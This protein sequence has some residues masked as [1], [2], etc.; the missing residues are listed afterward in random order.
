MAPKKRAGKTLLDQVNRNHVASVKIVRDCYQRQRSSHIQQCNGF[1]REGVRKVK[2]QKRMEIWTRAVRRGNRCY[3]RSAAE[4]ITS[5][6]RK[7]IDV[8]D[9]LLHCVQ[10]ILRDVFQV[11]NNTLALG[12]SGARDSNTT[13][14]E[15]ARVTAHLKHAS[16]TLLL[17]V[18]SAKGKA[19]VVPPPPP[20]P[21]SSRAPSSSSF[22]AAGNVAAVVGRRAHPLIVLGKKTAV[23]AYAG[24]TSSCWLHEDLA[25]GNNAL[26]S[27][28]EIRSAI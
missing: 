21:P 27:L 25:H 20:P 3:A 28:L 12:V 5:A 4:G 6:G 18:N 9:K 16:H 7:H 17:E 2:L 23:Q 14:A 1:E 22:V 10:D 19:A 11:L 13:H 15:L 26:P 24:D 8:R